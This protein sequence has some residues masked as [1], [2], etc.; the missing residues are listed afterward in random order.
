[1]DNQLPDNY[2]YDALG[3]LTENKAAGIEQIAW[4]TN[5]RARRIRKNDADL[6]Y[7]Y[8]ALGH[9]VIKHKQS[10]GGKKS[11]TYYVRDARGRILGV[12]E[13]EDNGLGPLPRGRAARGIGRA[14]DRDK[15]CEKSA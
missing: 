5:D 4:D 12:Y 9:R 3:R 15:E 1:M 6:D 10:A 7:V 8:D 13:Q 11:S 14:H 2:Q